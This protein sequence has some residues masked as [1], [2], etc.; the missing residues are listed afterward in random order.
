VFC[1]ELR[2]KRLYGKAHVHDLH[3]VTVAAGQVAACYALGM[4]LLL[5]LE[6]RRGIFR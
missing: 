3:G 4:P 2:G 5:L 1:D 6:K